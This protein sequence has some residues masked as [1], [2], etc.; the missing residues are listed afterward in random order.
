MSWLKMLAKLIVG[1]IV[2]AALI[3]IASVVFGMVG[4]G[5]PIDRLVYLLIFV[6]WLICLVRYVGISLPE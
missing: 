6:V 5:Y 3:W 1:V 4:I 2:L